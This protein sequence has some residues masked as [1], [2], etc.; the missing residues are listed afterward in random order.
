MIL[1][2]SVPISTPSLRILASQRLNATGLRATPARIEV[3]VAL[4]LA[5]APIGSA[6]LGERVAPFGLEAIHV[7]RCL[8]DLVKAGL[9]VNSPDGQGFGASR[10]LH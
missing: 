8:T 1:R 2:T 6:E 3:L 5:G 4:E 7:R 10:S 9:V